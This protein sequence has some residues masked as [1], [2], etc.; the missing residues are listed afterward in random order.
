MPLDYVIDHER[1]VVTAKGHGTLTDEDF[2]AYQEDVWSRPEVNGYNELV[3]LSQVE[4]IALRSIDRL[5]ELAKLSAG[6][7]P[8]S[9][10]S[11]FAIVAPTGE[12]FGL[13]RMYETYRSMEDSSTKQ[14]GVFRTLEEA[15]AF[16]DAGGSSPAKG[17]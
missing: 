17:S 13:A 12:A 4:H 14:V 6:M 7:D 1:R 15:L 5:R 9:S 2:F 16:L 11:R 3:D 10:A 8:R